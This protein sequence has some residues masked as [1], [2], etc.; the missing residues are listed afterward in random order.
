MEKYKSSF[1]WTIKKE[2]INN[3]TKTKEI[4]SF[5]YGL[6]FSNAIE[7]DDFQI[8]TIKNNYI[9]N[10]VISR[11]NKLKISVYKILK[12]KIY[13][14]NQEYKK[15]IDKNWEEKLTSFFAGVFCGGGS[16][17]DKNSTSYHLEI[18]THSIQNTEMIIKKLNKY[19]F[20]FQVLKRRNRFL[21]YTKKIDELLDFLSAIGAKKSWFELQ[22]LKITRDIE[23]VSNRIN[24]IDISNLQKIANSSIKHIENINYIFENNLINMFNDDQL[25][26]FRIKLENSWISMNEMVKKLEQEHNIVITKS[27]LNH[28]LRKLNNIVLDHKK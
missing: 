5:L 22:N 11:L 28:W 10:K 18:S 23:N 26:F 7:K 24:N 12:N 17:S 2:I 3:I 20:N 4:K 21:A 9:L 15:I 8:I 16:I 14:S 13:I 6:Y 1:S 27:G 19:D 25:V